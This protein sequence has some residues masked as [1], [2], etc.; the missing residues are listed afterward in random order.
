MV[1]PSQT[2]CPLKFGLPLHDS[3]I[4]GSFKGESFYSGNVDKPWKSKETKIQCFACWWFTFSKQAS[5]QFV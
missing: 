2:L 3:L 4:G 1:Y 5:T